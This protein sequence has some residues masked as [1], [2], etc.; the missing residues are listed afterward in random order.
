MH[1][2]V[3]AEE[4]S[5]GFASVESFFHSPL[6][7]LG[8]P[9]GTASVSNFAELSSHCIALQMQHTTSMLIDTFVVSV[10]SGG[11]LL[12]P[13]SMAVVGTKNN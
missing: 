4:I 1:S 10:V 13:W 5:V 8:T 6:A 9:F 3:E 12:L 7:I 11:G 2:D